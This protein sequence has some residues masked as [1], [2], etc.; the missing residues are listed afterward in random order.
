MKKKIVL[1]GSLLAGFLWNACD[2]Y[3]TEFEGKWQLTEVESAGVVT[4]VDTVWYNFQ[5][6][7]L[8]LFQYQIY[9]RATDQYLAVH[10]YHTYEDGIL[11]L[12]L[13]QSTEAERDFLMRTD[14]DSAQ[15]SFSVDEISRKKL[16]L[17]DDGKRYIFR[18]F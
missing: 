1:L 4:S 3:T 18:K 12:D 11:S 14:W 10:G 9:D 6:S 15:R 2:S 7:L 17:S 16:I 5:T 13:F 8:S